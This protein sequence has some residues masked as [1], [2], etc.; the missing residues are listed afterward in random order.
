MISP[1]T[2]DSSAVDMIS[3]TCQREKSIQTETGRD[4]MRDND[5]RGREREKRGRKREPWTWS[6]TCW[7]KKRGRERERTIE[8]EVEEEERGE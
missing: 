5:M 1:C 3:V 2:S 7:R 6:V 8:E 4:E